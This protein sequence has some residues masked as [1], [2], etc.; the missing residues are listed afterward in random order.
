VCLNLARES[1]TKHDKRMS[2]GE[3]LIQI[4]GVGNPG[5]FGTA[6]RTKAK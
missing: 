6:K 3:G 2:I 5:E 4:S 1:E